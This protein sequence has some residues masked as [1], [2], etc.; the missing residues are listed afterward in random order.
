MK[1]KTSIVLLSI[2]GALMIGSL[3]LYLCE[4]VVIATLLLVL[5]LML[6]IAIRCYDW[7]YT[8]AK[9]E[10][11]ETEKN[12]KEEGLTLEYLLENFIIN[13]EIKIVRQLEGEVDYVFKDDIPDEWKKRKVIEW[14]FAFNRL[15]IYI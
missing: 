13:N 6:L 11:V 1:T 10:I 5:G 14:E 4:K 9:E 15:E 8:T 2:D 12:K 3:V 7:G